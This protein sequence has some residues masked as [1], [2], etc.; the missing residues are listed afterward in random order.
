[1]SAK[2]SG[3]LK[4]CPFCGSQPVIV[5]GGED[6]NIPECPDCGAVLPAQLGK[7][8]EAKA[9]AAWNTR[10]DTDTRPHGHWI[11]C[12]QPDDG[13]ASGVWKCSVCNTEWLI[14]DGTPEENHMNYCQQCG[15]V[16]NVKSTQPPSL[17]LRHDNSNTWEC[18]N[19][20]A[21]VSLDK[22]NPKQKYLN[23]CPVCG[24]KLELPD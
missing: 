12:P 13:G 15:A 5:S 6:Y 10:V 24:T 22:G 1:M 2:I 17:W 4:P 7:D 8:S 23:Y 14:M 11:Y 3:R 16:M 19:C 20:H 9:I 21:C 18:S